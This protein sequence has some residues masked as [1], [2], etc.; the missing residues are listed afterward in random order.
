MRLLRVLA[1]LEKLKCN[2]NLLFHSFLSSDVEAWNHTLDAG[3]VAFVADGRSGSS[4]TFDLAFPAIETGR[5]FAC[6]ICD[7]QVQRS[8]FYV[9]WLREV[10]LCGPD[11]LLQNFL[12]RR[13]PFRISVRQ[14]STAPVM[15]DGHGWANTGVEA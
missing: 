1:I 6:H 12:W 9:M 10:A 4:F 13:P 15:G 11:F 2:Q 3:T 7:F 8:G 14:F 5:L